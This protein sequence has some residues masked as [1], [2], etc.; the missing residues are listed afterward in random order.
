MKKSA[1]ACA[2]RAPSEPHKSGSGG[3]GA[4]R[5]LR[6]SRAVARGAIARGGLGGARDKPS[7]RWPGGDRGGW[8]RGGPGRPGPAGHPARPSRRRRRRPLAARLR[9]GRARGDRSDP[10][11]AV[12]AHDGE[13]SST[14]RCGASSTRRR[15]G[16][17]AT[18]WSAGRRSFA[19]PPRLGACRSRW[20]MSDPA[21]PQAWADEM[22]AATL[23]LVG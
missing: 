14:R 22:V 6:L 1:T 21:D 20:S 2:G 8:D 17:S 9:P 5:R 23:R 3:E 13:C 4:D 7:R 19:P 16:C 11:S 12:G 15:A 10:R 18:I